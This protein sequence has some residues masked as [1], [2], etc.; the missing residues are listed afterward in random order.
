MKGA[1][2]LLARDLA[3]RHTIDVDM[4]RASTV[5]D[6]DPIFS[7]IAGEGV[8]ASHGL[9]RLSRNPVA[10]RSGKKFRARA[11]VILHDHAKIDAT[12]RHTRV[13]AASRTSVW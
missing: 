2:A 7:R 9:Q 1:T 8:R 11:R 4:C 13:S 5:A 12:E 6:A 3:V 10:A